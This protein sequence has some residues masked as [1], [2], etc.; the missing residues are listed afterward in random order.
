VLGRK[1]DGLKG[2]LL[3]LYDLEAQGV[4]L[5]LEASVLKEPT[6]L[7]ACAAS[8]KGFPNHRRVGSETRLE[9]DG[10]GAM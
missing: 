2:Q 7:G 10:G 1:V 6:S 3:Q 9:M 8:L 4:A 5:A